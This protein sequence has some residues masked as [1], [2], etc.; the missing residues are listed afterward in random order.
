MVQYLQW[1]FLSDNPGIVSVHPLTLT[2]KP[3]L[4]DIVMDGCSIA[5]LTFLESSDLAGLE[6]IDLRRNRIE[7]LHTDTF[8]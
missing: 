1:L 4:T 2:M 8:R 5:D 7:F 3:S 6:T